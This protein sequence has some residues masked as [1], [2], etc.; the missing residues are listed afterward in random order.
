MGST[1]K[2]CA[3]EEAHRVIKLTSLLLLSAAVLGEEVTLHVSGTTLP[4][5]R[6][7]CWFY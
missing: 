5:K 1:F 7:L 2:F 6:Y 3:V 4:Y